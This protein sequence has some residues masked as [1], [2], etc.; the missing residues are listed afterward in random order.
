MKLFKASLFLSVIIAFCCIEKIAAQVSISG[1]IPSLKND[2]VQL[3]IKNNPLAQSKEYNAN[4][5]EKGKFELQI[6][7][8]RIATAR[9]KVNN[10]YNNLI[11]LPD[12]KF[13]IEEEDS[14]ITFTGKGANKNNFLQLI[15]KNKL[16]EDDF[17]GKYKE[18]SLPLDEFLVQLKIFKNS[19]LHLLDDFLKTVKLEKEYID[20]FKLENEVIYECYLNKYPRAYSRKNKIDFQS[21]SLPKE[22]LEFKTIDRFIS[23]DKIESFRYIKEISD[24]I[25]LYAILIK[26]NNEALN[27]TEAKHIFMFDTLKGKT[28]EYILANWIE[29]QLAFNNYDSL[30]I[31]EFEK[32]KTSS[33]PIE[34]VGKSLEKRDKK[35]SLLG[36]SLNLAFQNTILLD[37]AKNEITLGEVMAQQQGKVVYLDTW[38]MNC[39]PC[40]MAMPYSRDLK[41]KL[42]GKNISFVFLSTEQVPQKQWTK[43]YETTHTKE[44]HYV[45]KHG[46]K[47][48]FLQLMEMNWVPNY[49]IIDKQGRLKDYCADRPSKE[50]NER[51]AKRLSTLATE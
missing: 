29:G 20:Y 9:I 41:E 1:E 26:E 35:R 37:T 17:S 39:Y 7:I 45:L 43:V 5:D 50:N 21:L 16:S 28:K 34:V 30:A 46:F 13:T 14:G 48:K 51:L 32:I 38:A 6:P 18:A 25:Y 11:I 15:R 19:R 3:W 47:A 44:N 42:K 22:Y 36:K 23:D 27:W 33:I 31:Q 10:N 4:V 24:Y 2:Q 8:T 12:D 49:M 40:R